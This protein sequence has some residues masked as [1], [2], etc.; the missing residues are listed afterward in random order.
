MLGS[1]LGVCPNFWACS[2]IDALYYWG[3]DRALVPGVW[4]SQLRTGMPRREGAPVGPTH[5]ALVPQW[6]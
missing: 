5:G 1:R 4:V 6:L 2:V 3:V